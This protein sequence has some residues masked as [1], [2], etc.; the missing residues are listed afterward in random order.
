M[1][2]GRRARMLAAWPGSSS[3]ISTNRTSA[4]RRSPRGP[5]STAPCGTAAR[6]RPASPADTRCGGGCR[7]RTATTR[8]RSC[9]GSWRRGPTQS[10]SET[11]RS[12]DTHSTPPGP[13]AEQFHA[14]NY[15]DR[16]TM[17]MASHRV[18]PSC[19]GVMLRPL[20]ETPVSPVVAAPRPDWVAR[21]FRPQGSGRISLTDLHRF[22]RGVSRGPR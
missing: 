5:A 2:A 3:N 18:R 22:R 20:V 21:D 15:A 16:V 11:S 10:R 1:I 12:H 13:S 4:P 6:P 7:P 19:R 14:P 17:P 9:R 8:W